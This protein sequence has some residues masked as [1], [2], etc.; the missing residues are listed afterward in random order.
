LSCTILNTSWIV[1]LIILLVFSLSI[2]F[3]FV[4]FC[5]ESAKLQGREAEYHSPVAVDDTGNNAFIQEQFEL[6][7][8][9]AF[10]NIGDEA[11]VTLGWQVRR[12]IGFQVIG[13]LAL[14]GLIVWVQ[15]RGCL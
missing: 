5:E 12:R 10:E 13:V 15:S 14:I 6:L 1:A 7:K 4:R 11:L 3:K 2:Y 8:R 9:G